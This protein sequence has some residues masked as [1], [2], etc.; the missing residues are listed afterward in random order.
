LNPVNVSSTELLALNSNDRTTIV[1]ST[2]LFYYYSNI[3]TNNQYTQLTSAPAADGTT[4]YF[5]GFTQSGAVRTNNVIPPTDPS[6]TVVPPTDG[7]KYVER[8]NTEER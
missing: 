8:F 7:G 3:R 2:H 1:N 6:D 5:I 4:Q